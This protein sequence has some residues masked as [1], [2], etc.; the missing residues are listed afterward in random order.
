MCTGAVLPLKQSSC[1]SLLIH[2]SI[3]Y[4]F[5]FLYFSSSN[6]SINRLEKKKPKQKLQTTMKR[7][8][9]FI[10]FHE[11]IFLYMLYNWT[12]IFVGHCEY[13]KP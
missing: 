5:V 8:E 9:E 12:H 6:S 3:F 10:C 1:H 13:I 4:L 11:G 2:V 7:V